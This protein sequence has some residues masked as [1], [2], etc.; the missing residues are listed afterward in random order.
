M[1]LGTTLSPTVPGGGAASYRLYPLFTYSNG[2]WEVYRLFQGNFFA[3]G[4]GV[5]GGGGSLHGRIFP[6]RNFHE[7]AQDGVVLFKQK[8]SEKINK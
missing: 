5:S 4:G 8:K 7:G 3:V 6:W 2:Y 1:S